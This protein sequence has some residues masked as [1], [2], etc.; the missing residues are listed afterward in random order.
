M[1]CWSCQAENDLSERQTCARCGAP[2]V[3]SSGV[4]QKSVLVGIVVAL[5]LLQL[6]CVF[7]RILR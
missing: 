2:L 7:G 1:T 3:R 6:V 5:L 4:F